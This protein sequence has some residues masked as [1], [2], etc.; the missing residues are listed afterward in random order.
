MQRFALFGSR[1]RYYARGGWH[2]MLESFDTLSD[3]IAAGPKWKDRKSWMDDDDFAD[4]EPIQWWHVIDL[5]TGSIV[6]GTTVQAYGA[7]DL[8]KDLG[9]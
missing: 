9:K 2:D 4:A 7:D 8:P 3:A 1:H 6:A 5:H